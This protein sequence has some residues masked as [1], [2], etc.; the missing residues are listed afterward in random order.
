VTHR[1]PDFWPNPEA[2]DPENFGSHAPA[3][4]KYAFFPFGGGMR[5]CIGYQMALLIMRVVVATVAQH[6][7]LAV[8]PGHPIQR[9]ALVALRPLQGIQLTV[10][11]HKHDAPSGARPPPEPPRSTTNDDPAE[12]CPF[13]APATLSLAQ[14]AIVPADTGTA[15]RFTWFPVEVPALSPTP[16]AALA[17]KRIIIVNGRPSAAERV[18]HALARG[19]ACPYIFAPPPDADIAAAAHALVRQIGTVDGIVDLGLEAPFTLAGT[20]D[21]EAPMQ[22][23]LGLMHACYDDWLAEESASR[24][25]YLAVT[26]M[27]GRMGYGAPD[28]AAEAQPGQP[29]GGLWAGFAKTLPQELPNCNVRI[30]DLAP[31][32]ADAVA[33]R[34]AAELYRWDLFEIGY[35]G[36][37]RYTLQAQRSDLPDSPPPIGPGDVV[38]LSGGARGIGL[39]CARAI[40]ERHGATVVITGREAPA[41]GGEPWA[42]LDEAGFKRFAQDRLRAATPQNPVVAIRRQIAQLRRRRVLRATLDAIAAQGLPIQYR[43]CDVTDAAAVR[44]LCDA[45]GDALRMIIHNAGVDRPVRLAQKST[46]DFIDTVRTKVRGFANLCAAVEGR[47]NLLRFCNVGSLTGRWGGMTGETDYAAANEALARLGLW[48]QRHALRCPVK[49]LVW[50][51]WDGVGMIT[52]PE[53]TRRYVATMANADGIRHWLAELADS[54]SGEVMFMGAVGGAVTPIQIRGFSPVHGLPNIAELV[55]R[56]HH[57]GEPTLFRPFARLVTRYRIARDSAPFLHAYRVDGRPAL[58]SA[59]LL[60]HACGAGSWITPDAVRDMALVRL[61]DIRIDLDAAILPPADDGWV[62]LR[63]EATGAWRGGEWMV[64]VLC[65]QMATGR[66]VLRVTLVYREAPVPTSQEVIAAVRRPAEPLGLLASGRA[67]W[68]DHLLRAAEWTGSREDGTPIRIGRVDAADASDLWALT[69]PPTLRLPISHI[70]TVLRAAWAAA[71]DASIWSIAV[72]EMGARSTAPARYVVERAAG[73]FAITDDQGLV[74]MDLTGVRML[75]PDDPGA[76][77]HPPVAFTELVPLSA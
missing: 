58:P 44:V 24:R 46:E 7:D 16:A 59:I 19:A 41:D 22:R 42:M 18:A 26:W 69:H 29:F 20:A 5:K 62:D 31:D 40:A 50:P 73:H 74:L 61:T 6:L 30:L 66:D 23:T 55:T 13:A 72:I 17:G 63:T 25:F 15:L 32:E 2:F 71:G 37:R 3:R 48:A 12:G 75:A 27:D 65:T 67:G 64:D 8:V 33:Q 36:G 49:T 38:L 10:R 51:T 35:S 57:A 76:S 47:T 53:V 4:H 70:E 39:L 14:T 21:W 11:P 60:E 56:H 45:F 28:P 9:G 1:H 68:N 77:A 43:V 54:Q 52:N 34:V